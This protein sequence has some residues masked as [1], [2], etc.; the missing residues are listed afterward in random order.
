M[1]EFYSGGKTGI[2][3]KM[4]DT[5]PY[6]LLGCMVIDGTQGTLTGILKGINKSRI[7]TIS[8]FI[9]YYLIGID[10]IKIRN[11]VYYCFNI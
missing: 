4:I 3:E 2:T 9:S 10:Q 6:F 11:T 7:V 1:A 5:F 8:T